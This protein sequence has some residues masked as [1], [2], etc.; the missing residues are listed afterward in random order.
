MD[1]QTDVKEVL[2]IAYYSHDLNNEQVRYSNSL[3]NRL[4]AKKSVILTLCNTVEIRI[5]EVSGF[6][7]VKLRLV[8]E[9]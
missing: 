5:L 2:R 1:G 6:Q 8:V 3:K 7:M 9:W 4:R